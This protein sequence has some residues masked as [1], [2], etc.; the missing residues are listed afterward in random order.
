[1]FTLQQIQEIEEKLASMSKKDSDF[2]PLD[3]WK[4]LDG[5]DYIAFIKDGNN[6]SV[7]IDQLYTYIRQNINSDIGNALERI[8]SLEISVEELNNTLNTFIAKTNTQ[9]TSLNNSIESIN[10]VLNKLTARYTLTVTPVTP[11]AI[12][13]I[14]GVRRNSIKVVSGSTVN[15]KVSAEGYDTYEE[16]ILVEG[17][18]I[19]SPSLEQS[20]VTFAINATP[21]DSVIYINGVARRSITVPVGTQVNWSVSRSGYITKTGSEVVETSYTL[22]ITL[23]TLGSDE[24]N[25]TINVISP[26]GA[27]VTING[28]HNNSVTVKKGDQVTWSVQAPHYVTQEGSE[29]VNEDVMKNVTLLAEQ[30]TLTINPVP[31]DAEVE[32]NSVSQKSILVDY[33]TRVHI[34]VSKEGYIT[35]EEDYTVTKT[36]TKNVTL[37][38]L[39]ETSW[40]NLSL[41]QASYSENPVDAVPLAGGRVAFKAT[42]TVHFNDLSTEERDV[43]SQATWSKISGG[44][45]CVPLGG[46]IYNWH[47]NTSSSE[48]ACLIT[49]SVTGPDL[50]ELSG[51][52]F[53]MQRGQELSINPEVLTFSSEQSSQEVTIESNTSWNI[54]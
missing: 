8:A 7:T 30:F 44:N 46:G 27:T 40:T 3:T 28:T 5:Q 22:P 2:K 16:F 18:I 12:V 19:L 38:E 36:E 52:A 47:E 41:S 21:T 20:Q 48:R 49:A 54:N 9:L 39:V 43:T 29:Y 35:Y 23:E 25:F 53:S 1:M 17:N 13:F 26:I 4:S 31:A 37:T 6:R 14:N 51:M 45:Y 32:L 33:N 50:K 34:K 11:N 24:V 10:E 42:V 15:V